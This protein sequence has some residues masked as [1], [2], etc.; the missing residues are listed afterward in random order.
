MQLDPRDPF[1][2]DVPEWQHSI[3][4]RDKRWLA[5]LPIIQNEGQ[6]LRKADILRQMRARRWFLIRNVYGFKCTRC[7]TERIPVIHEFISVA[8]LPAPFNGNSE[9]I[10]RGAE[11]TREHGSIRGQRLTEETWKP[12]AKRLGQIEPI[13]ATQAE[14]YAAQI[15]ERTRGKVA[16]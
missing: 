12:E 3:S 10:A 5:S 8:C 6:K 7:S 9:P 15:R 16:R 4:E 2:P 13:T 14:V 1:T 11:T